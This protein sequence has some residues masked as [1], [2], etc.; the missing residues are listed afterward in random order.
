MMYCHCAICLRVKSTSGIRY[1]LVF[2]SE[3]DYVMKFFLDFVVVIAKND[4][5]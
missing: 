5:Q 1:Y 4:K 2:T 3:W